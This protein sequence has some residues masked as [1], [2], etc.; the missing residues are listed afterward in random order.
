MIG[1]YM[2]IFN[3]C[4]YP[5]EA[6]VEEHAEELGGELRV[7]GDAVP[8]HPL[9]DLLRLGAALLVEPLLQPGRLR[10]RN[11]AAAGE[12]QHHGGGGDQAYQ[13]LIIG[14]SLHDAR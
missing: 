2:D 13:A 1:Q 9:R 6:V 7:A 14:A 4:A 3:L 5:D 11:A 10:R 12:Y 8:H